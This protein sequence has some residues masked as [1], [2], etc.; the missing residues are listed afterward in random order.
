MDKTE[1]KQKLE[2][3]LLSEDLEELNNL[4]NQF[5]VFNALKL[6]NNE[7]R[8]SNFL[9]WLMTPYENHELGDYFLK[10]FL[11]SAIKNFSQN[12]EIALSLIDIAYADYSDCE[13]KREH[14]NIDIL[15]TSNKNEF[16]CVIENKIRSGEHNSPQNDGEEKSQLIKYAEY[17]NN[18]Y[19][20]YKKL[21][22][23]L[24]PNIEDNT[25]LLNRSYI[26]PQKELCSVYYIPMTYEQVYEV[27]NKTLKFKSNY[28][29]NEVK[30]F[31]EHYQKMIERNI[32]GNTDKEIVDLCRKIYRENKVAIDLIIENSDS[33]ADIFEALKEVLNERNDID[34]TSIGSATIKFVPKGISQ[35][36]FKFSKDGS[37]ITQA[38]IVNF[39]YKNVMYI[40]IF[41][42]ETDS[43]PD[44]IIKRNNLKKYLTEKLDF[45]RFNGN[46][47]WSYTQYKKLI[48]MEDYFNCDNKEELKSLIRERLTEVQDI[49]INKFKE[50]LISWQG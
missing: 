50:A 40:E 38:Q 9:G 18:H 33:R 28:M 32:M 45:K 5:N 23:Y 42:G 13:I 21:F 1:Q 14:E 30:I 39:M 25:L 4:T 48:T 31:I 43:S 35:E 47:E 24:A 3:L 36:K 46:D 44:S 27:I 7:I 8:H 22:I 2:Q 16:L 41:I 15:I 49:Y 17:V 29:N 20:S 10:E 26:N 37:L 6:Q 12:N 34:I 11:K 19:P